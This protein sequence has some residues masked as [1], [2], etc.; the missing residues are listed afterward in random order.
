MAVCFIVEGLLL[1]EFRHGVG[2]ITKLQPVAYYNLRGGLL[3]LL[4]RILRMAV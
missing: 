1:N 2:G 3:P 4:S